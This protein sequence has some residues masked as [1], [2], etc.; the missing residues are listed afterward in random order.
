MMSRKEDNHQQLRALAA[1]AV[2]DSLRAA[3]SR[4]SAADRAAR[5]RD[6]V[7]SL[8]AEKAKMEVF[9]RELPISVHLVA[10][11]IEWLKEELAQHRRQRPHDLFAPAAEAAAAAKDGAAVKAEDEADANDKRS[12][13]SSAQL[14]SCGSHDDSTANTNGVAAAHNKV[15]TAFKPTLASVPTLARSSD[16]A[17]G[18]PGAMPVPDLSLSSP[19]SAAAAPSATS[20]AVTGA[21]GA[22]RRHGRRRGAAP[23]PAPAGAGAAAEEGQEVL[24]ARAAPPVRRRPAAARRRASCDAEADRGADEGGR[25]HQR[26][27][28]EPPA[29]IQAAHAAHV[30]GR[31]RRRPARGGRRGRAVVVGAGAAVRD[32]A[33]QHVA[34]AVRVAAGA[35]AADGVEQGH[36]GHRRGQLR[37]RRRGRGRRQV[38]ELRLG[39][40]GA[41]AARDKG[42]VVLMK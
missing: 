31:R 22:Q 37:R 2:T 3:A 11:V 41:A 30:V 39:D 36:V 26:R 19:P 15:S 24:V 4:S 7:R 17:A 6:C 42:I 35:P 16:D 14:W 18:K 33:A 23:A 32:V 40:A 12:W 28:Q 10:D 29:E 1:R 5:F 27:G 25:A 34:V 9:H 13:M 21:A 8:E 20:S 38:G